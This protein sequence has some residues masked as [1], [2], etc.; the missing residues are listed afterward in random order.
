VRHGDP[1]DHIVIESWHAG[2]GIK[3]KKRY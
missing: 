2:E 3:R 1:K